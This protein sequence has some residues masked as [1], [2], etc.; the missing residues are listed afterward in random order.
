M[1]NNI[2]PRSN[3]KKLRMYLNDF[4]KGVTI[5]LH[6]QQYAESREF[7]FKIRWRLITH[8]IL[9]FAECTHTNDHQI[10][11]PIPIPHK[12]LMAD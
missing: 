9:Y 6:V 2:I 7:I 3:C 8:N 11:I 4:M 10:M 12:G 5:T 1:S